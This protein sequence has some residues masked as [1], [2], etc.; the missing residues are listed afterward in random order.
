[1]FVIVTL[2]AAAL[3]GCGFVLQQHA[4]EQ[5]PPDSFLRAGLVA[6]LVRNRRWLLGF[7]L[8]IAGD[9]LEAWSLGHLDLSIIEPLLTTSLIFAL[10]LA[11]PLSRQQLR[12]VEIV[13]ALLLTAGVAALSLTRTWTAPSESF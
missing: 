6:R 11:V 7:A 12:R 2:L 4:A 10:V 13:G 8:L 3:A 9:L 1:M 5:A